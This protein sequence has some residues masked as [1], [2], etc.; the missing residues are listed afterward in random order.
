MKAIGNNPNLIDLVGKLS[1]WVAVPYAPGVNTVLAH[2]NTAYYHI[3]GI[4]F[5]YPKYA[6]AVILTSGAGAWGTSGAIVEVIPA[7]A[8]SV[9]AFDLHWLSCVDISANCQGIIDIYKGAAGSEVLISGVD[10]YRNAVQSQ[11]GSKRIQ[12]PQQAAGERISCKFSTSVAGVTTVAVKF[13]GH[14][15]SS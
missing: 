3:H 8:L 15:Y 11:E 5:V 7:G 1:D 12:V 6:D 9:A 2:L 14:Y 10:I 4:P 13:N